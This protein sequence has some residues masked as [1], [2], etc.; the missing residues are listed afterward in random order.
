MSG[1][2]DR[3]GSS[4][5]IGRFAL[6]MKSYFAL[7]P[8]TI[9]VGVD[10]AA[11]AKIGSV[12]L[13]GNIGFDALIYREPY[14]HFI[15]DF[16]VT[17]E[18]SYKGHSLSGVR[19]AGTI[20]GPGLWHV[21]G[22]VS[23]SILWWDISKSIDETWGRRPELATDGADVAALMSAALADPANWSAQLPH[24]SEATVTLAPP[25][26]DSAS[27]A[28]PLGRFAVSQRVAPLGV[29]LDRYGS[30]PVTGANQFDVTSVSI[31]GTVAHQ[32]V[33][34]HFARAEFVELT[35]EEKY[36]RPA[37]EALEAGVEFA[38]HTFHVPAGATTGSLDYERTAYLDLDLHGGGHTRPALGLGLVAVDAA[39]IAVLTSRRGRRGA[40]PAQRH[41]EA[42]DA[43]ARRPAHH[44]RA[45]PLAPQP[46]DVDCRGPGPSR[47]AGTLHRLIAQATDRADPVKPTWTLSKF[48]VDSDD[49]AP[50]TTSC[51][52]FA[53]A[54][55]PASAPR[56][57]A[58]LPGRATLLPGT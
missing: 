11:V 29:R 25:A 20:E 55:L 58:A 30:G 37:F 22:E 24:S 31:G 51:P 26:D 13:H 28:H 21:V 19:V 2:L 40:A 53:A 57:N 7:T 16:R 54:W 52:G 33:T 35:E 1:A 12:G 4:F 49:A 8:G 47:G 10:L 45:P 56:S 14:T 44:G 41:Y 23:F 32:P 48:E 17:V 39:T 9:Q 50:V 43:G 15:A 5:S 42:A 34:E 18:V 38:D 36:A 46:V 6:T 3:L 27:L